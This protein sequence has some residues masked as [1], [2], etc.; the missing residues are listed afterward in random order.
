MTVYRVCFSPVENLLA[1]LHEI[2][3]RRKAFRLWEVNSEGMAFKVEV[4]LDD[5]VD[6]FDCTFSR[7]GRHLILYCEGSTLRIYSVSDAQLIKVVHLVGDRVGVFSCVGIMAD[8]RQVVCIEYGMNRMNRRVCLWYVHGDGSPA[9][10]VCVCQKGESVS[11]I[12]ISP[13]DNSIA[14]MTRTGVIKLAH[15]CARDMAWTV[16][17]LNDGKG[18]DTEGKMSFS[19]SGQLLATVRIDG[20]VQIWDAIKGKC[21]RTIVCDDLSM[22]EFSPDGSLLAATSSDDRLYL[23]NI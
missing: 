15:R 9:E 22:L 3:G 5:E 13:F 6:V 18:F 14:I 2:P 20:G 17:V 4:R 23:Y 11:K 12:N 10:D 7:D 16:E 8:G 19:T 1:S 21:L